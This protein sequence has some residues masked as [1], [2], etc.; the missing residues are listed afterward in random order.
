MQDAVKVSGLSTASDDMGHTFKSLI[1]LAASDKSKS[2]QAYSVVVAV[3][4]AVAVAV[5]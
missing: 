3:V 5:A 2:T 4:V 1:N